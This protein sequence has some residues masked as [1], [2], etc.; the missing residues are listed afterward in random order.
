MT[1]WFYEIGFGY[2]CMNASGILEAETEDQALEGAIQEAIYHAE[3]FGFYLDLEFFGDYDQVGKD[4]DE[5]YESYAEEG[6]L[7]YY[8]EPYDPE[9]HNDL[10]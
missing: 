3:S 8:V 6:I 4:F 1:K 9:K 2:E 10:I 5:E 7:E